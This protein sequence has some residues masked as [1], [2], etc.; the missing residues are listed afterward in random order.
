MGQMHFLSLPSITKVTGILIASS[1][2]AGKRKTRE[3]QVGTPGHLV[4]VIFLVTF[5]KLVLL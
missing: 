2:S 4:N 1:K 5:L 3:A